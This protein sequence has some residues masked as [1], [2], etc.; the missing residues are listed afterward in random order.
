MYIGTLYKQEALNKPYCLISIHYENILSLMEIFVAM[1]KYVQTVILRSNGT[2]K[3][4]SYYVFIQ[5]NNLIKYTTQSYLSNYSSSLFY[6]K[7]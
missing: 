3:N 6:N 1:C 7:T 5:V 2:M 4:C